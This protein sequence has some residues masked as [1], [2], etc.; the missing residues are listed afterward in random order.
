VEVNSET[1]FV[2]R[3]EPFQQLVKAAAA[4]AAALLPEPPAAM[5][6]QQLDLKEVSQRCLVIWVEV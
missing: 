6:V 1:D 5:Q 2:G 3:S 4:A